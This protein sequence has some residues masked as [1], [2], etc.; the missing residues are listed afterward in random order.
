MDFADLFTASARQVL[1][2]ASAKGLVSYFD[3]RGQYVDVEFDEDQLRRAMHRVLCGL[4]DMIDEGILLLTADATVSTSDWC[5]LRISA[6]SSS[7]PRSGGVVAQILQRLRLAEL[8]AASIVVAGGREAQ[9]ICT[10]TGA[11]LS[12]AF[13]PGEGTAFV[14]QRSFR[15]RSA[16]DPEEHH[17]KAAGSVAWLIES[18]AVILASIERRLRRMGW[19][20]VRYASIDIAERASNDQ[21]PMLFIVGESSAQDLDQLDRIARR[22]PS[23]WVVLGVLNGSRAVSARSTNGVDVRVLPLSPHDLDAFT[24]WV[25]PATSTPDS[26]TT[27]PSRL[28]DDTRRTILVVDDHYVNQLVARGLL[29]SLGYEVVVADNGEQ[30]LAACRAHAPDLV[31]MDLNMP[32]M[33]GEEAARRLRAWQGEGEVPPFPIIAATAQHRSDALRACRDSQM[34]GLLEKPLRREL[35]SAEVMRLLPEPM[36]LR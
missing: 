3:Y 32:G 2:A 20:I 10:V 21:A 24:D 1:P 8:P 14:W 25:D 34:D 33:G 4:H 12:F 16:A 23:T 5:H 13:V 28:Y 30:A 29:E 11:A 18:P 22:W 15:M 36:R 6:A 9:G 7:T 19:S 35:L 31:L 27:V 26:L 17:P